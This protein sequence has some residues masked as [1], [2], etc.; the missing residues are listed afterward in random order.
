MAISDKVFGFLEKHFLHWLEIMSIMGMISEAI[1]VLNTLITVITV[2]PNM[3]ECYMLNNNNENPEVRF[4]T[5][6]VFT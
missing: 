5:F 6:R 2:S 3:S 1:G 4:K